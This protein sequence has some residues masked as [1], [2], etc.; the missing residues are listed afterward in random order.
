MLQQCSTVDLKNSGH[1]A[2]AVWAA[3]EKI[4]G[5]QKQHKELLQGASHHVNL[6]LIGNVDGERFDESVDAVVSI[7]H[8]HERASSV[9]PQQSKLIAFILSKLNRSTR[10]SILKN[11]PCEFVEHGQQIPEVDESIVQQSEKML[12]ELRSTKRVSARGAV[13][14]EFSIN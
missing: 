13:R 7:A 1:L 14:C 4:G 2:H 8:D 9:T 5:K 12:A 6:Q 10:E 3:L 11:I